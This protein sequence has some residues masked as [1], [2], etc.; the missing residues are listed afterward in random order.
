MTASD[1]DEPWRPCGCQER[2]APGSKWAELNARE[3]EYQRAHEPYA[4]YR[5]SAR[6]PEPET[7]P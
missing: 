3:L 6:P 7:Q 1:A 5:S 4:R 2:P